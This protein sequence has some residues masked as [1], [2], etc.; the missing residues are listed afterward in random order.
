MVVLF[1]LLIVFTTSI[2]WSQDVEVEY[3]SINGLAFVADP[4]TIAS[5]YGNDISYLSNGEAIAF[6]EGDAF[7]FAPIQ[8]PH[9]ARIRGMRC[10]VR[11]DT[12]AGYIQVTLLRGAINTTDDSTLQ[13]I[14]WTGTFP[15]TVSPDF[16][17][18]SAT[19]MGYRIVRNNRYGY[20][21]RADF[22]DNPAGA[23]AKLSLRGCVI[24][25]Q[26]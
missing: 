4:S 16:Q 8:L 11:D 2:I 5:S 20:F 18:I 21:L 13:S 6:Q 9:N 24:V 22:L 26:K 7:T 1:V 14:A 12:D 10:V 23:S 15:L 19:A 3:A 25:L 17:Q